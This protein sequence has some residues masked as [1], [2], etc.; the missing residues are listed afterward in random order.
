MS[1][2]DFYTC[3][4]SKEERLKCERKLT[5]FTVADRCHIW[6][7]RLITEDGYGYIYPRFREKRRKLKVHRLVYFLKCNMHL[8]RTKHISHLCHN[9]LCLNIE[10]LSYESATI[11]NSRQLCR[12][13]GQCTGHG[14]HKHCIF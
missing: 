3:T 8:C 9:K 12:E 5:N 7:G 11:N 1:E 14:G 6:K 4:L 10:H 13:N 2:N